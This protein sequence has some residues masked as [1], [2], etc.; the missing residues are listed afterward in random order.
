LP[1]QNTKHRNLLPNLFD[2]VLV[3]FQFLQVSVDED[4]FSL[5]RGKAREYFTLWVL[6]RLSGIKLAERNNFL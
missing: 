2:L 5:F 4:I 3:G 6:F 1:Q